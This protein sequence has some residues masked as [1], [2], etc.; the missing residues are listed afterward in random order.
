MLENYRK[1]LFKTFTMIF[2]ILTKN[3]YI[4][5][6][7]VTLIFVLD[8]IS[9]LYVINLSDKIY[10]SEIYISKILNINLIWNEGIAFGLFSFDHNYLYNFLSIIISF[11]ILVIFIMI[12]NAEGYKKYSLLMILGGALGNLFDR[13]FFRAVPDFIDF[14]IKEFHWFIFNVAD[15]FI[16]LGVIFM[17]L[18]ELIGINKDKHEKI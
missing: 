6:I 5:L 15:I 8:R 1:S 13:I 16:T 11:V 2:K 7:I 14:H 4:N 3:F 12:I 17:I 9:K 10:S 18:I